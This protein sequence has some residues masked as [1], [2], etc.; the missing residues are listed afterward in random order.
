MAVDA[1]RIGEI[2]DVVVLVTGDGDFV[3]LVDYMRHHGRQVEAIAFGETT[4]AKLREAVDDFID[5]SADKERYLIRMRQ[6]NQPPEAPSLPRPNRRRPSPGR[7]TANSRRASLARTGRRAAR[8]RRR[9]TNLLNNSTKPS[10][11]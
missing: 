7:S 5:L 6:K 11:T 9:S 4:S 2:L 3:D 8:K 1:I 10:N